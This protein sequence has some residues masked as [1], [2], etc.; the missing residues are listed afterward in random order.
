M[1]P[2]AI[3]PAAAVKSDQTTGTSNT[4]YVTPG[5]QQ[6]HD[7]AVKAWA[8][9]TCS[10]GAVTTNG[11]YGIGTITRSSAGIYVYPHSTNFTSTG[12][13]VAGAYNDASGASN[14]R[15]VA[16][17][18]LATNSTTINFGTGPGGAT[19]PAYFGTIMWVGRQ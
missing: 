16:I 12:Y 3:V 15:T 11:S 5:V 8:S 6:Y 10:G 9:I 14:T 18:T 1:N 4:V 13:C 19:D 2:A 17:N 7:S